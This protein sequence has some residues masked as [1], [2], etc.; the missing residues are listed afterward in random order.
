M[1]LD[2]FMQDLLSSRPSSPGPQSSDGKVI[3]VTDNAKVPSQVRQHFRKR[4]LPAV[5][6]GV[7]RWSEQSE[8]VAEPVPVRKPSRSS[9]TH[10]L[11]ISDHTKKES[12]WESTTKRVDIDRPR[13]PSRTNASQPFKVE[14]NAQPVDLLLTVAEKGNDYTMPRSSSMVSTDV[15]R[16]HL[17]SAS[18]TEGPLSQTQTFEQVQR[19]LD[20]CNSL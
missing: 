2:I 8:P 6:R 16:A 20:I 1:S 5:L 10:V 18:M 4:S 19:A 13:S 11:D 12:R 14:I 15:L 17:E 7:Q 3:I 9:R